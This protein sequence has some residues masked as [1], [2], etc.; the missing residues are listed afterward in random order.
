LK[1]SRKIL[2]NA[3]VLPNRK[4]GAKYKMLVLN[5]MCKK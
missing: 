2:K 1:L 3:F 5:H 4:S